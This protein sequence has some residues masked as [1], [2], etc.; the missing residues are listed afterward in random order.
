VF[1]AGASL[2]LGISF[3]VL[4]AGVPIAELQNIFVGGIAL[5]TAP[6][7]GSFID[8]IHTVYYL[9]TV[10]LLIGIIPSVLRR[11]SRGGGTVVKEEPQPDIQPE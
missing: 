11:S 3:I 9:S 7:I 1:I 2:S 8:S 6:W 5:N 10:F 4:T